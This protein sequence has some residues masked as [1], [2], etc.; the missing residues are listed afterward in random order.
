MDI[1]SKLDAMIVEKKSSKEETLSAI[2]DFFTDNPTPPDSDVH[3]LSDKMG[4]DTHEFESYIYSILGSFLSFGRAK[5]KGFTEADADPNEL[6]MGIKVELEHTNNPEVAKRI[7]IDHLAEFGDYYT[8][9][10]KMEKE[11][12]K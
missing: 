6:K 5:E 4:I 10:I 8:R 11:A 7:A 1:L 3:A 2:M 9:L 12:E